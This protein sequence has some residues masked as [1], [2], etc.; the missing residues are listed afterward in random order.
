MTTDPVARM[1]ECIKQIK[2]SDNTDDDDDDAVVAALEE[3]IE[4]TEQIDFAIGIV[5]RTFIEVT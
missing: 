2:D 3:L 1:R 4:W 5:A